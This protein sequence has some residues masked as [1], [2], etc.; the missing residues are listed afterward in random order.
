MTYSEYVLIIFCLG[1]FT[2]IFIYC[3]KMAKTSIWENVL[4]KYSNLDLIPVSDLYHKNATRIGISGYSVRPQGRRETRARAQIGWK[5][6]LKEHSY[7]HALVVSRNISSFFSKNS[8][9][10]KTSSKSKCMKNKN[11]RFF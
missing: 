10:M 6:F 9:F 3:L 2:T 1:K 11:I 5:S 8:C 4:Y 7:F